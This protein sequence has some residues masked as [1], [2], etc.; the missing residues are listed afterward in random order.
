MAR[1]YDHPAVLSAIAEILAICKEYNVVCGHPHAT[2]ANVEELL[3]R[4]FRY[5]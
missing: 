2:S 4:G 3:E 1:Q 5:G